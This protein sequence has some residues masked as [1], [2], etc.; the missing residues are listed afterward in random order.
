MAV[1]S[2]FLTGWLHF[3]SVSRLSPVQMVS[4]AN[5]YLRRSMLK[6]LLVVLQFGIMIFLFS[7]LSV[8]IVQTRF[9]KY[10]DS[11]FER[12]DLYVFYVPT[13]FIQEDFTPLSDEIS[14][15]P[16][17]LSATASMGI[18]GEMPVIQNAWVEGDVQENAIIITEARVQHNYAETYRFQL[19][20]G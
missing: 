18:P 13:G 14:A 4:G 6:S 1:M 20:K 16:D 2:G 15:L 5:I 10:R 11:G 8:L 19:E 9:M 7:V 12:D 17:V 3:L